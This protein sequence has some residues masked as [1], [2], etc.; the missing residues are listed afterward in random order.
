MT[1]AKRGSSFVVFGTLEDFIN[2]MYI[3]FEMKPVKSF[4]HGKGAMTLFSYHDTDDCILTKCFG[5]GF[6]FICPD[7]DTV[8]DLTDIL[9]DFEAK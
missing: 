1:I 6:R 7:V 5:S 8:T 3:T 4:I 2:F 9:T